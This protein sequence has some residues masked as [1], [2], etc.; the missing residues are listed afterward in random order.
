MVDKVKIVYK[1]DKVTSFVYVSMGILMICISLLLYYMTTRAGYYY[2]SIGLAI[3]ALYSFGKGI[4]VFKVANARFNHYQPIH[5]LN[6]EAIQEEF[7]YTNYRLQKKEHNRRRYAWTLGIASIIAVLG[8]F[9]R[10]KGLIIG[11]MI[12]I[13]LFAAMEFAIGLLVEFRLWEFHRMLKK[14]LGL[15]QE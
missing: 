5:E 11:T 2:L 1:G 3:F 6:I 8:I 14:K 7:K 4:L 13:V 15:P 10:E 12:P 9:M